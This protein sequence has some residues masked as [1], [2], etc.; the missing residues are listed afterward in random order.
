M[1]LPDFAEP[2]A[3]GMRTGCLG[4]IVQIALF[5][6]LIALALGGQLYAWVGGALNSQLDGATTAAAA[7]AIQAALTA[8][9]LLPFALFWRA[10][11]EAAIYRTWLAAA[12]YALLLAPTRLLPPTGNAV[13]LLLQLGVTLMFALALYAIRRRQAHTPTARSAWGL[14]LTAGAVVAWPWIIWG[15]LGSLEESLL[16]LLLGLAF[17]AAAA[18]LLNVFWL[19]SLQVDSRGR[20]ADLFTGGLVLGAALVCM[21]SGLSFNGLQLALMV[22]LPSLGFAAAALAYAPAIAPAAAGFDWRAP[23]PL[24]GLAAAVALAFTDPGPL[25]V[26]AG[27]PALGWAWQAAFASALMGFFLALV[28]LLWRRQ[29]G[30]APRGRAAWGA[31]AVLWPVVIAAYFLAGQPG[32]YGDRLFVILKPQ[33]DVAF[34][35]EITDYDERRQMVYT[36]LVEHADESQGQLR[37][38]LAGWGL[39]YTPYYL[40]N[41]VEVDG[42][43]LARLLLAAQPEVD[44]ILPS[45]RLRP[46]P[47]PLDPGAGTGLPAGHDWNLAQIHATRVWQEL[48]VR[49]GGIV[50]GQSD[51]GVDGA[52]GE[53]ADGYRGRRGA[54]GVLDHDYAWFDPWS[55]TA[56]P[57]DYGGHGTHTLATVAGNTTGVA[58]DA[59]W[60]ACANLQR[61]LGNP[62]LYL[63]CLQFM[64]APFPIGGNPF[65]AG[66][67]LQSAHVLNNSWGCPQEH[68][69][70]DPASLQGAVEALAAAGLFVVVSAGN[71]GPACSTIADPLALYASAFTVGAVNA[72]DDLAFFSSAGPV[73]ADG[74]GRLKPDI[75]APG[76]DVWSAY[77]GGGYAQ[78]SGTSMAGPHV[79]GVV[80]LMW[81][82]NPQLIGDIERTAQILRQTARPFSGDLE[83]GALVADAAQ[84]NAAL[85]AATS[86]S[87]A[88]ILAANAGARPNNLV[89]YGVVDAY[90]AVRQALAGE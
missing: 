52:H 34:A 27:D 48:G 44:R 89:G 22:A 19:R 86:A 38:A 16:S 75:A 1:D 24:L 29:W 55:H 41:A 4:R 70:C 74:C 32:F 83:S 5:L 69:G 13:I 64:L 87:G 33:A 23:A 72:A 20:G 30:T 88:C 66:D 60:I 84:P 36:T 68:E 8:I 57:V 77:P 42:G 73:T 14:A 35:S 15:A 45:P 65:T 43:L 31:A 82:A 7:T 21:A 50:I 71:D 63:D 58:P 3:P 40:V 47:G 25:A 76:V 17:G 90:A 54:D 9:L 85:A 81:S 53:L 39:R 79:A 59:T 26:E 46:L 6:A 18:L 56:A 78:M 67:P 62:A 11:R 2:V 10:R 61:N 37:A 28:A 12:L 80:A 49:G 51:S